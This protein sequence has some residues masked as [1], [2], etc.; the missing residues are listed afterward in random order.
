MLSYSAAGGLKFLQDVSVNAPFL[1]R[2][3][4]QARN[5]LDVYVPQDRDRPER[6][7]VVFCHGGVW[8]TGQLSSKAHRGITA[9]ASG[10]SFLDLLLSMQS[11]QERL[12]ACEQLMYNSFHL[13]HLLLDL[14]SCRFEMA[15]LPSGSLSG[16]GRHRHCH[17]AAHPLSPGKSPTS[18]H[19]QK[20]T[21]KKHCSYQS[22]QW[23]MWPIC[24]SEWCTAFMCFIRSLPRQ[25]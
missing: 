9:S 2:Y 14:I 22:K 25:L 19:S 20:N 24:L 12:Q 15:L 18:K 10:F 5:V 16:S 4:P 17:P 6:P 1:S 3:G 7:L 13:Q 8:S 23:C 21:L 11:P